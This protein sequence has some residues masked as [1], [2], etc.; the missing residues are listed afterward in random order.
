M[1]SEIDQRPTYYID[2]LDN[3]GLI[4]QYKNIKRNRNQESY[5]EITKRRKSDQNIQPE[6]EY[7]F[8]TNTHSLSMSPKLLLDYRKSQF[9]KKM[10]Y[11]NLSCSCNCLKCCNNNFCNN[12]TER[13]KY[14]SSL[15]SQSSILNRSIKNFSPTPQKTR[16][17]PDFQENNKNEFDNLLENNENLDNENDQNLKRINYFISNGDTLKSR[18]AFREPNRNI[19]KINEDDIPIN[20]DKYN[21]SNTRNSQINEANSDYSLK[22]ND[23]NITNKNLYNTQPI[24]VNN[25]S[26]DINTVNNNYYNTQPINFNNANIYNL[27]DLKTKNLNK[28]NYSYN[29]KQHNNKQKV[30]KSPLISKIISRKQNFLNKTPNVFR[31]NYNN[32]SFIDVSIKTL[33]E[34]N[35]ISFSRNYSSKLD[36]I[37]LIRNYI[38]N[39]NYSKKGDD[40][41][42]NLLFDQCERKIRQLIGKLPNEGK[43]RT[44]FREIYSDLNVLTPKK[45]LRYNSFKNL[46]LIKPKNI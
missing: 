7:N 13:N 45:S 6:Y 34:N 43:K 23:D 46:E 40:D 22:N 44:M 37:N 28:L 36:S 26:N 29:N 10:Y 1:R 17:L 21:E 2:S 33:N 15:R 25:Y 4:T 20:Y 12:P 32:K 16:N 41:R 3:Q 14:T 9:L 38:S 24:C 18:E 39:S 42:Y 11:N 30:Y 31:N 19:A 35:K 8:L 27:N 5:L